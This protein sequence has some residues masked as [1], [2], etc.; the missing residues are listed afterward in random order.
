MCVIAIACTEKFALSKTKCG[1]SY[2][3]VRECSVSQFLSVF[4][5]VKHLHTEK[6]CIYLLLLSG[7]VNSLNFKIIA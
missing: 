2:S 1:G 5:S 7:R 3:F 6:F 4:P